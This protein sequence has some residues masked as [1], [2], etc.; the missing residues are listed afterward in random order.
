VLDFAADMI[1]TFRDANLARALEHCSEK[2]EP[3]FGNKQCGDELL[4]SAQRDK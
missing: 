1:G 2:W 4:E 3:V